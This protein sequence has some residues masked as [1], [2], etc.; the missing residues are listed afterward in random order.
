MSAKRR[1]SPTRRP[2]NENYRLWHEHRGISFSSYLCRVCKMDARWRQFRVFQARRSLK[3]DC[4]PVPSLH[5][6]ARN[7]TRWRWSRRGG[8]EECPLVDGRN[9]NSINIC[10]PPFAVVERNAATL[11]KCR[12]HFSKRK[13]QQL[14]FWRRL[15][16]F[17]LRLPRRSVTGYFL[18]SFLFEGRRPF[19][20]RS[21]KSRAQLT[22]YIYCYYSY[23]YSS[24]CC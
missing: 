1:R 4:L 3:C 19:V 16:F 6:V 10:S 20:M 14:P 22:Y 7:S 15:F 5:L 21:R 17:F 24:C 2:A 13:R 11:I 9:G 12:L 18:P 8:G 23:Y